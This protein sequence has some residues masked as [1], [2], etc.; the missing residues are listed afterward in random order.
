MNETATIENPKAFADELRE[1]PLKNLQLRFLNLQIA[2]RTL[3]D[4]L[5]ERDRLETRAAKD[6]FSNWQSYT[7]AWT[8]AHKKAEESRAN[9]RKLLP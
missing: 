3:C 5:A 6:R 2:A 4:A 9:L 8:K 7:N 1:E